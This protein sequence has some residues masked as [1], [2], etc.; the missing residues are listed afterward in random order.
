MRRGGNTDAAGT[1]SG[2]PGGGPEPHLPAGT[3]GSHGA[4]GF[5]QHVLGYVAQLLGFALPVVQNL[6]FPL[7]LAPV[8]FG[9]LSVAN[10]FA[11]A[12][13]A[14]TEAGLVLA[15]I[16]HTAGPAGV[17]TGG[18]RTL[19]LFAEIRLV[20]SA[21][22]ALA[23]WG[24]GP[25]LAAAYGLPGHALLVRLAGLL[26]VAI[27]IFA[28]LDSYL[29]SVRRNDLSVL[30]RLV[31]NLFGIGL[32]LVF[33]VAFQSPE[34]V[35]GG[36][37]AGFASAALVTAILA[38]AA[39]ILRS[40][41]RVPGDGAP[42]LT[43]ALR[44]VVVF[45]LMGFVLG[46][47][48]W[49]LV[50]LAGVFVPAEEV[51][52]LKIGV[53]AV[54]ATVNLAP[55]PPFVVFSYLVAL[56]GRADDLRRYLLKITR[57][58][59][60]LSPAVVALAV[61]LSRRAVD[62]IYGPRYE[63][64]GPLMACIALSQPA[65]LLLPPAFQALT[66]AGERRSVARAFAVLLVVELACGLVALRALH[67]TGAAVTLAVFPWVFLF[68]ACRR[69]S[70]R[71][72]SLGLASF[73]PSLA[74]AGALALVAVLCLHAL[75]GFPGLFAAMILGVCAYAAVLWLI[76]GVTRDDLKW[77]R[78]RFSASPAA[79]PPIGG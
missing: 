53:G 65:L 61:T 47:Q 21:V 11:F 4:G 34:A 16:W 2:E 35:I 32:P 19:F 30:G 37:A 64:V 39:G 62:L 57:I 52:Y 24:A 76:G 54:Q 20:F 12:P 55:V 71:G 43:D 6:V 27:G 67:A 28:V 5:R 46:M 36:A 25:A 63:A 72:I 49:G 75:A 48:A 8:V 29:I 38:A 31:A 18:G 41:A 56:S 51:G 22:V 9:A 68:W 23:L 79:D 77:L 60:L 78:A 73:G 66:V 14:L 69:L 74:A 42:T 45:S 58:V 3:G 7:L 13:L 70:R 33:W 10:G 1:G 44:S 15:M 17:K 26:F 40:P 50:S 59:T